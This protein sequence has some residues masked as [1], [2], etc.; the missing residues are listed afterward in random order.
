MF[1]A[2]VLAVEVGISLN[3]LS[4]ARQKIVWW[5]HDVITDRVLMTSQK[6]NSENYL[7]MLIS[8]D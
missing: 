1:Y 6:H 7:T 5:G 4:L 3:C 2:T 8:F